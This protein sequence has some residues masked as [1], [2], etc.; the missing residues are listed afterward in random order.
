MSGEYSILDIVKKCDSF[1]YLEDGI[2]EY[3][4]FLEPFYTFKINPFNDI[5]GYFRED[6][7]KKVD[8]ETLKAH[9]FAVDHT[10]RTLTL[11]TAPDA[12]PV[13]RGEVINGFLRAAREKGLY[14]VLKGKCWRGENYP[15]CRMGTKE[16]KMIAEIERSASCL[17]GVPT[18]GVHMT[19]YV[20]TEG[21]S[22]DDWKIWIPHRAE[23]KQTFPGML[24]NVSAGGLGVEL[25]KG[26]EGPQY[27]SACMFKEASEEA[28]ISKDEAAKLAAP[29]GCL[30]YIYVRDE[31]AQPGGEVGLL[32]PE[33]EFNY[34][35]EITKAPE[36]NDGE[37]GGFT[38]MT[39]EEVM[40]NL[41]ANKFKANSAT[42]MIDF[43]MRHG[44]I[45]PDNEPE[46]M[47]ISARMHR[48]LRYPDV[49][50]Y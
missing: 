3:K 8:D 34:D 9:K 7:L 10:K 15:I 46:Y 47:E 11:M 29:I 32:Q 18:Y 45:T 24:D 2:E 43:L 22:K 30:T 14:E 1:P 28:D 17:F 4:K 49:S 5:F 6:Q 42:V 26:S 20:T 40:T 50:R 25:I 38:L 33:C 36:V 12:S 39:I 44:F 13:E 23:T 41:K 16:N 31:M 37:V 21:G 48:R 27:I 19:G 35:M